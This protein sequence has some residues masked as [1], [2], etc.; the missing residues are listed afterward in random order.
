M[1]VHVGPPKST[2][3]FPRTTSGEQYYQISPQNRHSSSIE[4][5]TKR[6]AKSAP[7]DGDRIMFTFFRSWRRTAGC[8]TLAIACVFACG[9]VRSLRVD[10]FLSAT[11]GR[12][13]IELKHYF[14]LWS[15]VSADGTLFLGRVWTQSSDPAEFDYEQAYYRFPR[16]TTSYDSDFP[17]GDLRYVWHFCGFGAY[18][19]CPDDPYNGGWRVVLP[20]WSIVLP[21]TLLSAWLLVS[22]P[23][24]AGPPTR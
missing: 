2:A 8:C 6:S 5:W 14:N 16:W 10:D 22:K 23:Q 1:A 3:C 11:A 7:K 19:R 18:E 24:K 15:L 20:Y 17:D 12:Q 21:L 4:Q 13:T 9:W